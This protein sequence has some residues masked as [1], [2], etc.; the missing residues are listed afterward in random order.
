METAFDE[1]RS[2]NDLRLTLEVQFYNEVFFFVNEYLFKN[3]V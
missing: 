2:L 1:I 3:F